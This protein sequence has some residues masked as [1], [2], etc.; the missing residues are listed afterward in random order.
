MN[1]KID[2]YFTN[3]GLKVTGNTAYGKFEGFEVNALVVP[4]DTVAPVK[5]HVALYAPVEVKAAI[6][7]ELKALK[8]KWFVADADV[9]GI[10]L[11]FNDA[12]TMG[13]LVDRMDDMLDK[14]FAVFKKHEAKGLGYC[15]VCGEELKE[16]TKKCQIGFAQIT[17][18]ISCVSDI[19]KAI[20]QDNEEF[21]NA[22]NNYLK[23]TIG[24]L[25][26]AFVGAVIFVV[27]FYFGI[28]SALTSLIAVLL[29]TYAYKKLGGKP[30]AMM[31]VIVTVISV[32]SMLLTITGIYV[33]AAEVLAPEFGFSSTGIQAFTDMMSVQEFSSEFATNFSMTA[34]FTALGVIFEVFQLSKSIKRQDTIK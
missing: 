2:T 15:P 11:G 10:S 30:N 7:N 20:T 22:P 26:G 12:L 32:V 18:D 4:L 21:K 31:I 27:L 19:N 33:L 13:R 25:L 9:Y 23:G 17:M 5:M 29:G 6:I 28:V 3:L 1:K 14:I 24:A 8:F 16:E 34:V